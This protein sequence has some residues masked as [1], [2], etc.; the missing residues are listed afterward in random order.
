MAFDQS[1]VVDKLASSHSSVRPVVV[2]LSLS[3]RIHRIARVSDHDSKLTPAAES[4]SD[5]NDPCD[6]WISDSVGKTAARMLGGAYSALEALS[7]FTALA[8][9]G[10]VHSRKSCLGAS[11]SKFSWTITRSL[12]PDVGTSVA[13]S[14]E[15]QC[16]GIPQ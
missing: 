7:L 12:Y 8:L 13:Y 10:L 15:V 16:L 5:S 3:K 4:G 1:L 14:M 2:S 11:S 9:P 6:P